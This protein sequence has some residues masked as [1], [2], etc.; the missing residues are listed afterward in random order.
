MSQTAPDAFDVLY[1]TTAGAFTV[2][3]ERAWAP[4][5]VDRFWQLS[6]LGYM[7]GAPF[8]RVDYLTPSE[9]FVVQ[10][11]YRGDPSSECCLSFNHACST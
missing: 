4:P 9:N 10:F 5:L 8:Y 11:G 1:D 7:V 3:S 2:H 6:V